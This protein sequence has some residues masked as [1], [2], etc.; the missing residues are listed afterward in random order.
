MNGVQRS[1]GFPRNSVIRSKTN[2]LNFLIF[3][4]NALV[5][6]VC[7][8]CHMISK[9]SRIML[10]SL[11]T[12]SVC[13]C[14]LKLLHT[15]GIITLNKFHPST[16]VWMPQYFIFSLTSVYLCTIFSKW[17]TIYDVKLFFFHL[18]SRSLK[19]VNIVYKYKKKCSIEINACI[20]SVDSESLF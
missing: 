11:N 14:S 17:A 4:L 5:E 10:T 6:N 9:S 15:V 1:V 3:Y 8:I 18:L 7:R 12:S 20:K 2:G 19:I 13:G 16:L